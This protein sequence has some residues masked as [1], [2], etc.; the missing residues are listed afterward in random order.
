MKKQ[1]QLVETLVTFAAFLMAVTMANPNVSYA[2]LHQGLR[3]AA[4]VEEVI[5]PAIDAYADDE[6]NDGAWDAG[7][8]RT[9]S[10]VLLAYN[11]LPSGHNWHG[12]IEFPLSAIPGTAEIEDATF[13]VRYATASGH[14]AETLRFNSYA[15]D[16]AITMSDFAVA[17]QIGPMYNAFGPQDGTRWYKVPATSF[18]QGLIDSGENYAGLM[19]ENVAWNQTALNSRLAASGYSPRLEVRYVPEPAT[20]AIVTLGGLVMLRRRRQTA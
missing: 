17:S 8:L 20:M 14:A 15:G 9:T 4:P 6:D 18:I 13:H 5:Y 19:I 16:G 12:V 3:A 10:T 11:S 1:W 2:E 7:T